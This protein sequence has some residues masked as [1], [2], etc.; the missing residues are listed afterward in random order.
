[1]PVIAGASEVGSPRICRWFFRQSADSRSVGLPMK[2]QTFSGTPYG[3][4][5]QIMRD[6]GRILG[7]VAAPISRKVE[8][9]RTDEYDC[10]ERG[11]RGGQVVCNQ[12]VDRCHADIAEIAAPGGR[13]V[14]TRNYRPEPRREKRRSD[15][16]H[17]VNA[18]LFDRQSIGRRRNV[19]D[20]CCFGAL[21]LAVLPDEDRAGW[22]LHRQ[23]P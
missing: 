16:R 22:L 19:S 17:E 20:A 12:G 15:F 2:W 6:F 10:P 5:L 9:L 13:G 21:H 14:F 11:W 4:F 18:E 8:A 7:G 3:D 1:M 23:C